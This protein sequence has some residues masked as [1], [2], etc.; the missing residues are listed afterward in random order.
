M[1]LVYE[2]IDNYSSWANKTFTCPKTGN[3]YQIDLQDIA[4]AIKRKN[5]SNGCV[6]CPDC[7]SEVS[8]EN[9]QRDGEY[10]MHK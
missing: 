10:L 9:D 6:R 3:E 7:G 4:A 1:K 5:T 2:G 8:F